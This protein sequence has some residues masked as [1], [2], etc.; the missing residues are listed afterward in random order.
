MR[1]GLANKVWRYRRNC[2]NQY[3]ETK[4]KADGRH[5]DSMCEYTR[6]RPTWLGEIRVEKET[7]LEL[8]HIYDRTD[9]GSSLEVYF[10]AFFHD[11]RFKKL[12]TKDAALR[13]N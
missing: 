13:D 1:A 4:D 8:L 10:A 7:P 9:M 11:G 12:S 6:N 3:S 5:L 2:G